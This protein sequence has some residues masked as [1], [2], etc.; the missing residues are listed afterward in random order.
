MASLNL[1]DAYLHIPIY[2]ELQKFLEVAI[3]WGGK[4]GQFKF[5]AFLFGLSKKTEFFLKVL[6]EALALFKTKGAIHCPL[7]GWSF[8]LLTQK[9]PARKGPSGGNSFSAES[10]VDHKLGKIRSHPIER[11]SVFGVQGG[12]SDTKGVP[13]G[14]E[15]YSRWWRH[16]PCFS[17][18]FQFPSEWPCSS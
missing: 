14:G 9:R 7:S 2:P 15:R 4:V 6:E 1:R 8:F 12:F 13:P 11:N 10:M 5:R 17:A 18:I 3:W 16:L